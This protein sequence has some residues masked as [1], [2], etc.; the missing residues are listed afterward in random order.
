[1]ERALKFQVDV[2]APINAV[3]QAWTTEAGARSFFAPECKV[4]PRPGGSYE[5][6]WEFDKPIGQ[7][8]SEGMV[9]LGLQA[10]HMLSFTWNA[11]TEMADV[12]SH[13]THVAVRLEELKDGKTRVHLREDGWGEGGQ[14]DERIDYFRVAWGKVVLPLLAYRFTEGPVDWDQTPDTSKYQKLVREN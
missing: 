4:D 13:R 9:F 12:R 1:M 6:Y 14:W 7:R 10:P 11:P 8:G 3:W 2:N 5:M